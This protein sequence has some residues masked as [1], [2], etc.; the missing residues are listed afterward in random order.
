VHL[1]TT[2][3][4]TEGDA[5]V[6]RDVR[7]ERLQ[8]ADS[9]EPSQIEAMY[10]LKLHLAYMAGGPDTEYF[11]LPLTYITARV[12]QAA[13]EIELS[14]GPEAEPEAAVPDGVAVPGEVTA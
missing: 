5:S 12:D 13:K 4:Q 14:F 9:I 7:L 3:P 6:L 2:N 11:R 1:S 8:D 10:S